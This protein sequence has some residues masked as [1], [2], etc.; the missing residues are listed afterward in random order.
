[1]RPSLAAAAAPPFAPD[2]NVWSELDDDDG[3]AL[4]GTAASASDYVKRDPSGAFWCAVCGQRG[5]HKHHIVRHVEAKHLDLK[6]T[7]EFCHK[8][9][10]AK[11][12]LSDHIRMLHK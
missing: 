11:Y 2:D 10:N 1:M 8:T 7:C 4:F 12:L 5:S 9:F 6:Y 3:G